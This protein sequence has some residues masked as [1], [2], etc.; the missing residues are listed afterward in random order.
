M[1]PD[2]DILP[3]TS[4]RTTE[5]QLEIAGC[6]LTHLAVLHGTPLYLYD[7]A[8]IDAALAAYRAALAAHWPGQAEIAYAAKAWL[9]TA[10]AQWAASAG[11]GLDVVSEGELRH[12]LHA[13]FP[14]ERLHAHGN[15][16]SFDFLRACVAEGVGR[17]VIDHP[18]EVERLITICKTRGK[19]Q[20]MWLRLNPATAAE[21]HS[22]IE[23]GSATSKFGLSMADGTALRVATRVQQSEWLDWQ[24]LHFHIGSQISDPAP[25]CEAIR[26]VFRW[27]EEV[28][29]ELDW[30]PREFSPGG[31]WA[32]PYTPGAPCLTPEQAVPALAQTLLAEVERIH[33]PLPTLVLEPGRELVARAG[34]AL[35]RVSAPKQAGTSR[36][37][38]LDGGLGDNPRP[39]LYN[40]PYHAL[41]ANRTGTE[42]TQ[43][44]TLAGPFCESGDVLIRDIAL[45]ELRENDVL[46]VPVSGAYQLSMASTY[47]GTPRPAVLWLREGTAQLIQR[48]ET[49]AELWK[50]DIGLYSEVTPDA[51]RYQEQVATLI[52]HLELV[53]RRPLLY[54]FPPPRH[55]ALRTYLA[56]LYTGS[57]IWGLE[58]DVQLRDTIALDRGWDLTHNALT[59]ML[60]RGLNEEQIVDEL[61][62]IEIEMWKRILQNI[63]ASKGANTYGNHTPDPD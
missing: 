5:G 35:Y 63:T 22:S 12:A 3:V 38:F 9:S 10:M 18:Q 19:Q 37:A 29:Q 16:K 45:P 24:G 62:T 49:F 51:T 6:S 55:Y 32:V 15:N 21:T 1:S 20:R 39:A 47:N 44:Y 7:Q 33:V 54:L 14:A 50:R 59:S 30:T 25:F 41:L 23:T 11:L 60:E 61:L 58:P 28:R 34:V 36:Y 56:A 42:V 31:G 17:V 2:A 13:G 43:S 8:T 46:A 48:R 57:H 52:E 53:Q 4:T 40:A 26:K 27:V